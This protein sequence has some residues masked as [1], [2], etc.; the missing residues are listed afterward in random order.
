[1]RV[2]GFRWVLRSAIEAE[3]LF[4]LSGGIRLSLLL[5][6]ALLLGA[7]SKEKGEEARELSRLSHAVRL[8]RDA[9][10]A[11]KAAP[12]AA[13]KKVQCARYCEFKSLCVRAY[14][15]HTSGLS[16]L[17]AARQQAEG[18]EAASAPMELLRAEQ[19]LTEARD[20]TTACAAREGELRRALEK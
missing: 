16:T 9:P 10:N 15:M 5:F 14:D 3:G 20:L 17:R 8:V 13:L 7:C 6:A 1:M 4:R 19:A 12:L 18:D 11:E 2:S